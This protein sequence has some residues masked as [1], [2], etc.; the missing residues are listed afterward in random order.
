MAEQPPLHEKMLSLWALHEAKLTHFLCQQSSTMKILSLK[1]LQLNLRVRKF[2]EIHG[3]MVQELSLRWS[4]FMR[5]QF[6]L[7]TNFDI[8]IRFFALEYIVNLIGS[9][10]VALMKSRF[11]CFVIVRTIK[12]IVAVD[13]DFVFTVTFKIIHFALLSQFRHDSCFHNTSCYL[14]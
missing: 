6:W 7:F 3:D 11:I 8:N 12:R 2:E 5:I 4:P 10:N 14:T 1:L 13:F 9:V